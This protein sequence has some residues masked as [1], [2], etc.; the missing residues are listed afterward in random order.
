MLEEAERLL[1]LNHGPPSLFFPPSSTRASES[2]PSRSMSV[3]STPRNATT[4]LCPFLG[5]RTVGRRDQ[6]QGA[7]AGGEEGRQGRGGEFQPRGRVSFLLLVPRHGLSSAG[8]A[9]TQ[10]EGPP[11]FFA[12][13][14]VVVNLLDVANVPPQ[15]HTVLAQTVYSSRSRPYQ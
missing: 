13:I 11:P 8:A 14:L 15:S 3:P 9:P 4:R 5:R 10:R 6:D 1:V 12:P 2:T 7:R